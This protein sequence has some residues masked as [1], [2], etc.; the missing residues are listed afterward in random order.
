MNAQDLKN[1]ILKK[2]FSGQLVENISSEKMPKIKKIDFEEETFDIPETWF[3]SCLGNCCEMYTGNSISESVKKTKYT[4]LKEGYDYIATKDVSFEHTI[5]Y[6]NGVKIPSEDKFRIAYNGS[7]LMCI[8]GGSAGRKIGILDRDVCFGNKLCSFNSHEIVNKYIYY[9]LQS[10][11]FKEFFMGNMSGIIGGVSIKKLKELPIPI[12]S[13]KEQHRIVAKLEEILP[14]I[15][16]YDKAYTKLEA[17]NKKFPEDM[18]KSILQMAV[19]GKL[20]EQRAEEGTAKELLKNIK[21]EKEKLIKEG[22]IK[23]SKPLPAITEDEIPFEIPSSWEWVRLNDICVYLQRGKSPKYSD[24]KKI[25]VIAQKCN[26][27]EGFQLEKAQFIDPDTLEKYADERLLQ[28]KDILINSTGLGTVGRNQIYPASENP[29]GIAVADSHVTVVRLNNKAILPEY[30]FH[31]WRN[32][33]VQL[34]VE[35]QTSGSTKQKELAL[36]TIQSYIVPLP[37]LAEQHRIVAKIE[38]LLPYC[39]KLTKQ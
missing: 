8:E 9:Y 38:E 35:D 17:F 4:G 37:P 26:Q 14:Y 33:S 24:I 11:E 13:V 27:W 7:I 10:H 20:V 36:A 34:I 21:A 2:A 5:E 18:K 28:N 1:S 30:F 32:P 19:Q 16:Q 23:K 3:W 25:P 31:Y 22:K 6:N 29:Y 12:P 39:D 15:D